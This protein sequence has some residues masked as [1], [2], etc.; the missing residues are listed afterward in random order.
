MS[1][2]IKQMEGEREREVLLPVN[3]FRASPE[4]F[5]SQ[6]REKFAPVLMPCV[7]REPS[8]FLLTLAILLILCFS[9][10]TRSCRFSTSHFPSLFLSYRLSFNFYPVRRFLSTS[11]CKIFFVSQRCS[12]LYS[13]K[14]SSPL[15]RS[16]S[17]RTSRSHSPQDSDTVYPLLSQNSCILSF[18]LPSVWH[19]VFLA[20]SLSRNLSFHSLTGRS[21]LFSNCA[22]RTREVYTAFNPDS[23]LALQDAVSRVT[24]T[25]SAPSARTSWQT[26]KADVTRLG[27]RQFSVLVTDCVSFHHRR[28]I[29]DVF[30]TLSVSLFPLFLLLFLSF[31]C[32]LGP[33]K[34]RAV[35]KPW[36]N[37]G[38]LGWI[39]NFSQVTDF[40]IFE[41]ATEHRMEEETVAGHGLFSFVTGDLVLANQE[42]KVLFTAR[43]RASPSRPTPRRPATFSRGIYS[44]E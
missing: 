6:T 9:L 37:S 18:P 23:G 26:L 3:I 43:R 25:H 42:E 2:R 36:D 16:R 31:S 35:E 34:D 14:T 20:T 40:I 4:T 10:F 12:S 22:T 21:S 5:A 1:R 44:R 24:R 17:N 29:E 13:Q 19:F 32:T 8:A 41:K 7:S 28:G 27:I 11:H 33:P 39:L 30:Q 38:K 15:F